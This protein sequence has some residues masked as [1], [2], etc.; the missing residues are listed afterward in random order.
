MHESIII[1]LAACFCLESVLD[2]D[3]RRSNKPSPHARRA[4]RHQKEQH[5]RQECPRP[6]AA[7]KNWHRE[8]KTFT[9]FSRSQVFFENSPILNRK[10]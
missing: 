5:P 2:A 4:H 8:E 3:R 1:P 10:K 7:G 6:A 9:R